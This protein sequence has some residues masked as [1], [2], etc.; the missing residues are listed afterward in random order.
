MWTATLNHI[1]VHF[2]IQMKGIASGDTNWRLDLGS[3]CRE[4]GTFFRVWAPF[5]N[6]VSVVSSEHS[7]EEYMTS[8]ERDDFGYFSGNSDACEGSDYYYLIDGK[9]KRADPVSRFQPAGVHGPSR[10]VNPNSFNW[11]DES[12]KGIKKD[13]MAIYELHVGTFTETGR[14]DSIIGELDYLGRDLGVNAI[15]IMPIAQ[16]PGNRNW[17]YDGTYMYAPQNSYGGPTELKRL[18][19]AAHKKQMAVILD[20]VYNHLGP[21]GNYLGDFGP[22]FSDK[23]HTFWGSA[24]NFDS[25]G[26][27]HVR[28]YIVQNALYW[29]NEYHIDALRL[30]AVHGIFDSSAKHILREISENAHRMSSKLG[31]RFHVIAE[32]DLNDPR[33]ISTTQEGGYDIDAQWNDDFHH[34]VHSYLTGEKFGYYVDFGSLR[35][36][37]KAIRDGF[38]YDGKYSKYRERSFGLPTE[39]KPGDKFVVYTQNHDQVGNRPDG[40]RLSQMLTRPQLQL[41]AALSLLSQNIPLIFMGE[42]YAEKS[43]FFYFIHHTD[44]ILVKA[45]REGRRREFATHQWEAEF[46]DPQDEATFL[47]SKLNKNLRTKEPHRTI[48]QYYCQLLRLRKMHPSLRVFRRNAL[49][50]RILEESQVLL[51]Y[52]FSKEEAILIIFAFGK[53]VSKIPNPLTKGEWTKI[54]DSTISGASGR[55]IIREPERKNE[56]GEKTWTLAPESVSIYHRRK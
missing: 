47:G 4:E 26:S 25:S 56:S 14:F 3:T 43:P 46:T 38:V 17:G 54:H 20:V 30:D 2:A 33:L 7:K 9:K 15:E 37:E 12:W 50:T 8:L 6:S 19:N 44:P 34:S 39:G 28:H 22:Y 1:H 55:K 45:V 41:A 27:D 32:S 16:F 24:I 21:E 18:V 23:Y 29:L 40:R 31:R 36:I 49:K 48:F 11:T 53:M 51:T 13:D 42:E 35:D 52:R 10:I 5:A